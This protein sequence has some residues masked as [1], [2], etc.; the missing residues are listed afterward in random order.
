MEEVVF[1][2][3]LLKALGDG[4]LFKRNRFSLHVKV[5]A[6]LLYMA[7]LSYREITYVLRLVPCS[8]EAVRL[9]VK[10][11]EQITINVEARP[12]RMVAVDE[13]KIK[14]D[15]E[16][17]YVWA[18]IDVDTRELLA[19]WV[20]WQRNI[21]HA[22]AFL[23]RALETCRNKPLIIVDKGPWYPEALKALGL[24]W[25]HRTFGERNRI[26]RWFRTM[27][28]RTRRFFNNFPVRKRPNPKIKR[29]IRLFALWYNFIRPHQTLKRPPATPI[30]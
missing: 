23:R 7:G 18:A 17:C 14:A 26:E 10:R 20:S 27:K 4:G 30:T 3:W 1:I 2:E 8:Y 6:V 13:T 24:E 19:I 16:W 22:E 11:L 29:F 12:R 21:L 28:A 25:V 5:R 9:W 15:G